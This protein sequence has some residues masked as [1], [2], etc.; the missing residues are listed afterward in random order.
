MAIGSPDSESESYTSEERF[1][2][3]LRRRSKNSP[4]SVLRLLVQ[5]AQ[6]ALDQGSLPRHPYVPLNLVHGFIRTV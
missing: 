1:E 5:K 6:E 2:A 3:P 4:G